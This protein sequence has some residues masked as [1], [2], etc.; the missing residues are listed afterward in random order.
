MSLLEGL[1]IKQAMDG[2][3][4]EVTPIDGPNANQKPIPTGRPPGAPVP[5]DIADAAN[6][7]YPVEEGTAELI[8][9][10]MAFSVSEGLPKAAAYLEAL[11]EANQEAAEVEFVLDKIA[12]WDDPDI[13]ETFSPWVAHGR[14][15]A[16]GVMGAEAKLAME[17]EGDEGDEE[18]EAVVEAVAEGI[19]KTMADELPDE[20]LTEPEVQEAVAE[21]A[22]AAAVEQIAEEVAAVEGGGEKQSAAQM[23]LF[24]DAAKKTL[25]QKFKDHLYTRGPD[26]G[27]KLTRAGSAYAGGAGVAGAGGA[28]LAGRKQS[29]GA[30]SKLTAFQKIKN[31]L[32]TRGPDGGVKLTRAGSAYAGGAGVAGAGGAYLAGRKQ[33]A[34]ADSK[35]TAFQ[36]IKN[37]LYTRQPDGGV[38]LTRA[39]S[40]YAGGA[41]VAGAGG[42]YLAGRKQSAGAD[43]KLTA[44]QK[45]K[46]H[47]YTRQPDGGVKLTR[48]GSAYAGGAGVAGAG[49]AYLAGRKQSA[50][51]DPKVTAFQKIKNHLYTRQPDGGVKL[52]RAGSAYAG[53]AGVAGAGGAYLAGRKQSAGADPKVTAFQKIKN[54]L[55]TRQPDGGVKLTRAGSAYAGGAGVAGAGG[56]YL[57]GRNG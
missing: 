54:H 11:D 25:R 31:H 57:A 30:D 3:N 32:Y 33:S 6:A 46:N 35:L 41:G 24:P 23:S 12:E 44:F 49:G 37:H 27:V 2:E 17:G 10:N 52:T 47:L 4:G 21:A 43:S 29:A 39:G 18:V 55:Y 56:A 13:V 19:A 38:K 53:G 15:V 9:Q 7:T 5:P 42:A 51:A 14:D 28:Y 1:I 34:G 45:I 36:K 26:G 22:T 20:V 40:A 16:L 8:E 48:A 50:G